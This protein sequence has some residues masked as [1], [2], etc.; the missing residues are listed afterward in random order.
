MKNKVL[1]ILGSGELGQQIRHLAISDGHFEV[2]IFYDDF[3]NSQE[4]KGTSENLLNDYKAGVFNYL[5][6]GIGYNHLLKRD[7]FYEKFKNDIPFYKL[8]HSSCY[9]DSTSIISDG[10]VLYPRCVIDKN[11]YIDVNTIL[12][13]NNVVSHNSV[14][15]RSNFLAPSVSIAGFTT[16]LNCCFIGIGS[17][18]IDNVKI[19]SNV[20]L[21]ASS[22]ILSDINEEGT[23]IFKS[24]KI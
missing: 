15:G 20:K 24:K 13:L 2:V 4:I 8:I 11:V 6:I 17:V 19:C 12:N 18:I 23:Y 16:I 5:L 3:D 10:V 22:L 9:V 1:A 14:I 7:F 21:G